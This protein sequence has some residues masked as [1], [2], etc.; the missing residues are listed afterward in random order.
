MKTLIIGGG[1]AGASCA[2]RLRRLDEKAEITVLEATDEISIAS[3]GLPYYLSDTISSEDALHVSDVQKFKNFFNVDV[4]LNTKVIRIDRENKQVYT[5]NN[6]VHQYD[7]LVIATGAKP[8]VPEIKGLD[9]NKTFTLRSIKDANA[10]KNYIKEHQVKDALIIGAGFIGLEV[11][12]NLNQSNVHVSI[13]EK[14]SHILPVIDD[15]VAKVAQNRLIENGID[16]YV[17]DEVTEFGEHS[18]YLQSGTTIE[19]GIVIMS[20]GVRANIELAKECGLSTNRGIIVDEQLRT[21]DSSIYA[22]GDNIEVKDFATGQNA[23][24]AL[25]GPANRQGRVI[26]D[27]INGGTSTYNATQGSSIVKIFDLQLAN[28]GANQNRLKAAKIDY[29]KALIFARSHASYYP[30]SSYI[31]LE[32]LFDDN[33][34]ILGAQAIGEEGVDKRIDVIATIMRLKGTVGDLVKAELCY[35]PPFNGAKDPVN[36][37]GMLAENML[38]G[39]IKP[40]Y[41]ED[42]DKD[43]CIVD[44]R[45][46][47]SFIANHIE[48]A[49]NI[50]LALLRTK[51]DD[52]PKDKKIIFHC[53]TGYTSYIAA[54]IA[55]QHGIDNVYSLLGGIQLYKVFKQKVT[56]KK[57]VCSEAND[58]SCAL[59]NEKADALVPAMKVNAL[60]LQCPGPIMKVS[61]AIKEIDEG[62]VIEVTTDDKG[63]TSDIENWC[64]STQNTLLGI[65][66]DGRKNIT[67]IQKGQRQGR[68]IDNV[69]ASDDAATIVIFSNDL[70]KAMASMV[71][72][73]G[74][75]AAGKK[76]TLFF[77]FW[78]LSLLR[79]DG[80][81]VKK[82]L[83]EKAFSAL[84]PKGADSVSLSKFNFF[85]LGT[86]FMKKLMKKKN[87]MTLDEL[88]KNAR[89]NGATF[90]ACSMSMDMMGIKQEELIDGVEIG[91]VANYLAKAG[92]SNTNL[93]I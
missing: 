3:C 4:L 85:G 77:T 60:S 46:E 7:K 66:E 79:S 17:N 8:F 50:P 83:I 80:I 64:L 10:I 86:S 61:K 89:E 49:I 69:P 12:E 44:L 57:K 38:T 37:L 5:Q 15:E 42:L 93:F 41:L 9:K 56:P 11:A 39:L 32:L 14:Q 27:N 13:V 68:V 70:D 75:L 30:G 6:S 1:A 19:F 36:L 31:L 59:K 72:A 54:R 22:A 33:G 65:K 78:G 48:G 52:L 55:M 18:A 58:K 47:N 88:M 45:D 23:L 35:A 21:S 91:G 2:A 26:A 67:L 92:S 87:I 71:I 76:V 43:A 16:V 53:N 40:A 84:L 25:A 74:A 28:V 81:K 20:I 62:Q 82:G 51:L 90:I 29:K 34:T 63:F 73:N 24:I